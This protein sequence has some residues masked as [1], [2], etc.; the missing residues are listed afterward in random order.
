ML[1]LVVVG[2]KLI[3]NL[4]MTDGANGSKKFVHIQSI[5]LCLEELR[6]ENVLVT[7]RAG[8]NVQRGVTAHVCQA[9]LP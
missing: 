7:E 1:L 4:L 8:T 6:T 5:K 9:G 3:N 2:E